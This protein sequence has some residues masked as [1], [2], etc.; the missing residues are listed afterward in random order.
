MN[1][2]F[3][4][5]FAFFQFPFPEFFVGGIMAITVFSFLMWIINWRPKL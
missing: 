1:G 2:F 4:Y 3:T 5:F